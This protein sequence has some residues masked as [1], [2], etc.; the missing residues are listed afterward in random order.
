MSTDTLEIAQEIKKREKLVD[1]ARV[2]VE[3]N[4]KSLELALK[5]EGVSYDFLDVAKRHLTDKERDTLKK[6]YDTIQREICRMAEEKSGSSFVPTR[7]E[8][9]DKSKNEGGMGNVPLD[10]V[11]SG[12]G[13]EGKKVRKKKKKDWI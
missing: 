11:L 12:G 4:E 10:V 2:L 7:E 13:I 8:G 1:E 6:M 3:Q 9:N 5:A